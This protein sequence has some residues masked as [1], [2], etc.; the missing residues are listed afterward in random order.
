MEHFICKGGCK[1]V[2][3]KPGACSAEDCPSYQQPLEKCACE[4]E[5]HDGA[6]DK[7]EPEKEE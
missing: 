4:D 3:E 2:S 6:F 5:K 1:G 7:K